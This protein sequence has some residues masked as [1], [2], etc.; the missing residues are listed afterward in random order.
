MEGWTMI[1]VRTERGRDYLD[2]AMA[3][4][5][6]EMRPADEEPKALEVMDRLARK[7]RDRVGPFDPHARATYATEELLAAARADASQSQ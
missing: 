4:E 6:L 1:L 5:V 3:E 2:R 7:Q